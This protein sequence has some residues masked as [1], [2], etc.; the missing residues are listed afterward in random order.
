MKTFKKL[1]LDIIPVVF[2]VL[3]ALFISSWKQSLDDQ[4]FLNKMLA[5]I[6]QEMETN[7]AGVSEVLTNHYAF[8]DSINANMDKD[9]SIARM[10]ETNLQKAN[11]KN[12]GWHS[13]IN[14][15]LE[16]VDFEVDSGRVVS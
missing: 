5:T 10:L 8:I 15:K 3:I 6:A 16:L 9:V 7:T 12:T 4:K 11:I 14:A 13:F 2:G 1:L